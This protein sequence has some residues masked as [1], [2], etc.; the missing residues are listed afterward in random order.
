MQISAPLFI[1]KCFHKSQV[2]PNRIVGDGL[3]G[4]HITHLVNKIKIGHPGMKQCGPDV[5]CG[6][7]VISVCDKCLLILFSWL[8]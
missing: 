5:H 6:S 2:D 8:H 1:T 7:C 4:V 3:Q